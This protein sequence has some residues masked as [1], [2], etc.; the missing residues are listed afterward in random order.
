MGEVGAGFFFRFASGLNITRHDG[1]TEKKNVEQSKSFRSF[2]FSSSSRYSNSLCT[3]ID[4]PTSLNSATTNYS[5]FGI[6]T[7]FTLD[8]LKKTG[9]KRNERKKK[10]LIQRIFIAPVVNLDLQ[11]FWNWNWRLHKCNEMWSGRRK[12]QGESWF[13]NYSIMLHIKAKWA[14]VLCR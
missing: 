4:R 6:D 8:M 9:A 5:C 7:L 14:V 13:H 1:E 12:S 10:K 3:W 2:A 11:C